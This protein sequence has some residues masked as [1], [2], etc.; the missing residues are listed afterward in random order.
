MFDLLIRGG[1]LIDPSQSIHDKRDVAVA[2][3]KIA[4]IGKNL[5]T[6]QANEV[7]EASDKLVTPG[8]IDLHVHVFAGISHYG[9]EV[10]QSCLAK[11]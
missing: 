10:D 1:T 6:A 4:A 9:I 2:D 8:L 5:D 11:A 7:I 3:G